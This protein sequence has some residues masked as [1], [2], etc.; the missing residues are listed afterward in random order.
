MSVNEYLESLLRET[1]LE[2]VNGDFD[3]ISAK[4][5]DDLTIEDIKEELNNWGELTPPPDSA[6]RNDTNRIG[7]SDGSGYVIEFELWID[8]QKSDL[9]LTCEVLVDKMQNIQSFRIENLH[10]L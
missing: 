4:L 10:V 2:F 8:N 6:Y 1:V 9:T 7:Y 5:I 3:K